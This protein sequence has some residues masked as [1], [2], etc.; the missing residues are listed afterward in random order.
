MFRMRLSR[1]LVALTIVFLAG[2]GTTRIP[3]PSEAVN[4]L[5]GK[6]KIHIAHYD[7]EK[8]TIWIG[9]QTGRGIALG[10]LLGG[11]GGAIEGGLQLDEARE[12]G[13]KFISASQLMDPV[14]QIEN[15]F[16]RAWQRELQLTAL[17]A[18]QLMSSDS[19]RRL[20]EQFNEGYVIDFKTQKWSIE[21]VLYGGL[22]SDHSTYRPSYTGR[23]RLVRLHDQKI[24]WE[25]TCTYA[26]DQT[27]T[28]TLNRDE[29]TGDDKGT[30]LKAALQTLGDACA[31]DLWRQFFGRESG[32]DFQPTT[33][34]EATK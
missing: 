34:T 20:Q 16:L 24:V 26:K 12:T 4:D 13:A 14:T 15:R 19:A 25:G 1:I 23:A 6:T 11:I 31:D 22:S 21:P 9:G 17:P 5:S 7:P 18:A 32:P 2:C 8:F 3:A 28:P 33:V 30:A 27:L 29:I 10:I